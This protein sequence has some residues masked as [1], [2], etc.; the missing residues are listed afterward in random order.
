MTALFFLSWVFDAP[1]SFVVVFGTFF[2]LW[3]AAERAFEEL[4][5][6]AV[7]LMWCTE[8]YGYRQTARRDVASLSKPQEHCLLADIHHPQRFLAQSWFIIGKA[9][10]FHSAADRM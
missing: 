2:L 4:P 6:C 8:R 10:Y 9:L 5:I 1:L 3:G 7:P